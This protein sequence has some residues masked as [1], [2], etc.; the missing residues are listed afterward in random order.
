MKKI[1]QNPQCGKEFETKKSTV[2]YCCKKCAKHMHKH[3]QTIVKCIDKPCEICGK[4]HDHTYGTG[5]FCSKECKAEYIAR[6][7][8]GANNPK[9]KAHLDK[10]RSEG[11][12]SKR[13][14]YGTW[15][16]HCCDNV[17]NTRKELKN[18]LLKEHDIFGKVVEGINKK[19]ACPYCG[20]E[21]DTGVQIGGH[22]AGCPNHPHKKM[23]DK[24]HKQRGITASERYRKGEIKN[25]FKGK[26]HSKDAKQKMRIATCEYLKKNN[27]TPCRYNRDSI[28]ILESIAKEHGWNIQH[29][30][31]G[32]EFYTGIGFWLDAYDKE[33]NIALEYDERKHYIDVENNILREKDLERQRLIIEH[34]HCEYWRYNATTGVLWKV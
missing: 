19:F 20:K 16:C 18:H 23:H 14:P 11:K 4:E 34:L 26:H 17:F 29:A 12:I 10:L 22:I 5:R 8:R 25:H 1:C 6:K 30:E 33:L 28:P 9:V 27:A 31:N 13:A 3:K 21:F 15:K 2:K 7:N 32:G 24:A